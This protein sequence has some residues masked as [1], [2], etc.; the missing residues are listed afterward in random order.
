MTTHFDHTSTADNVLAGVDLT[1]KRVL[2]TGVSAGLGIETARS[3]AA[4]GAT[5]V[6]TARN[7]DK[8]ASALAPHAAL[9]IDVVEC[10][11]AS[12]ASV[13][14]CVAQLNGRGQKFD[15][16]I[17]N[18]GVMM[19]PFGRTV[20]GFETQ[21]GTNHIGH[22]VLV[23]GILPLIRDGGR[24]V[25]LSSIGHWWSNVD[26]VDPGFDRTPYDTAVAYGRSKTAN[27]LFAGE[28]DRRLRA[29]GIRATAVHPGGIHTELARH[30]TPDLIGEMSK[31]FSDLAMENPDDFK[32]LKS[33]PQGAATSVWAGF[34]ASPDLVGGR[35]CED[36]NVAGKAIPQ[37]IGVADYALDES[38]ARDLWTLTEQMVEAVS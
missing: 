25:I 38:A 3:A 14:Q 12:L 1:G 15:V 9:G 18:A 10:D 28:L 36:C 30:M 13:R 32:P 37:V 29:R 24:I 21:F 5:V 11:L 34:V 6:G 27:A 20:D 35:Y 33:I 2:I 31:R 23:T 17:A 7:H 22:F 8:A 26:L 4:H 19:C 16:V